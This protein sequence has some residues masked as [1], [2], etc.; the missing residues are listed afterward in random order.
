MTLAGWIQ[1]NLSFSVLSSDNARLNNFARNKD[2]QETGIAATSSR[3]DPG[4]HGTGWTEDPTASSNQRQYIL[5]F[6]SL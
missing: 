4:F 6:Q 5:G 3:Q 1:L 2:L